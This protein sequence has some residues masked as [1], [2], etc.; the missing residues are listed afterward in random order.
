MLASIEVKNFAHIRHACVGLP[1]TGFC[2]LTGETGVGKSLL[3]DSVALGL[4]GRYTRD[5]VYPGAKQAE[6]S[7]L[8]DLPQDAEVKQLLTNQG[9]DDDTD[10]I[11]LKRIIDTNRRSRAFVN[12]NTTT[13]KQLADFANSLISICGQHEHLQL[14][15]AS[16]R[17]QLLDNYAD[18][19][20]LLEQTKSTYQIWY[21]ANQKV[22]LASQAAQEIESRKQTLEEIV[23]E[24]KAINLSKE[25][26]EEQNQIL[27]LQSNAEEIAQLRTQIVDSLDEVYANL[28]TIN[29]NSIRLAE[30]DS[31]AKDIAEQIGNLE[32][33]AQEIQREAKRSMDV[34]DNFDAS[35]LQEAESFI[36]ECQ[37]LVRRYKLLNLDKLPEFYE[38][39][40]QE[41]VSLDKDDLEKLKKELG[42]ALADWQQVAQKLTKL[43]TKN[44]QQLASLVQDSLRKL[45]MPE[46]KF[47]IKLEQKQN[48]DPNGADTI[49]FLFSARKSTKPDDFFANASGGE[50]SRTTLALFTHAN[51]NL[52]QTLIFDEVDT[53]IGGK[54]AA[55]VGSLLAQL[56]NNRLV[57]CVTHLPQVAA[58]GEVH[59]HVTTSEQGATFSTISGKDREEEIARMLAGKKIT[60]ASRNNAKEILAAAS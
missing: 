45:G 55:H 50:L 48:P 32:A 10:Q 47:A 6:I 38:E 36:A 15:E 25:Q 52:G 60:D 42:T 41:L 53:G 21:Q 27:Y 12:G 7:L 49:D 26:V 31:N 37:K 24:C 5:L 17:M 39:A 33:L 30:L 11:L 51:K 19:Q 54:T 57:L 28:A 46:A 43:R 20:D 23:A 4:G 14:K 40:Q 34:E 44:A 56:G 3:I 1:S 35:T 2:V 18:S 13:V 9:I 58:A 59:W 16:R 8:F 29:N 22:K